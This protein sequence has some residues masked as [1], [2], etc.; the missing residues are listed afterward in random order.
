MYVYISAYREYTYGLHCRSFSGLTN[1][2][3]RNLK[4][5][6]KKELQW[7]LLVATRRRQL[8]WRDYLRDRRLAGCRRLS[9]EL[10][11]RLAWVSEFGEDVLDV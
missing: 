9:S 2:I 3:P 1:F 10:P 4:G 8:G 5:N 6:P 7:R 11:V